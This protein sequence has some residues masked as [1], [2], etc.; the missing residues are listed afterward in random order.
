MLDLADEQARGSLDRHPPAALARHRVV[1]EHSR[2]GVW[3][4]SNFLLANA[5]SVTTSTSSVMQSQGCGRVRMEGASHGP[6][7]SCPGP[8][9]HTS[10]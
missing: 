3:C 10:A 8:V 7:K 9:G 2:D 4:D 6:P 1:Y 5:R